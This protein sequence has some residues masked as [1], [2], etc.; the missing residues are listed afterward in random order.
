MIASLPQLR[1]LEVPS[2]EAAPLS[3]TDRA[4]RTVGN[5]SAGRP[6]QPVS[7]KCGFNSGKC[8]LKRPFDTLNFPVKSPV[9]SHGRKME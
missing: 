6:R 4:W 5:P 1:L 8:A 2:S 7:E 9:S 3:Q